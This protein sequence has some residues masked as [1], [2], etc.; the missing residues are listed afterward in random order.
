MLELPDGDFLELAWTRPQAGPIVI[1][2]H[3]LEGSYQSPYA[4]GIA[5]A[6]ERT[7]YNVVIAHFRGCGNRLNRLPRNYHAG[8][9]GDIHHVVAALHARYPDRQLACI[10]Y[11]LGGNQLLKWLGEQREAAPIASA[12]A[13]SVPFDLTVSADTLD[14]GL[15]RHY[16]RFLVGQLVGKV[17]RKLTKMSL[18]ANVRTAR[19]DDRMTF[20]EF[21]DAV[22]APLHGFRDVHH[23]YRSSSSRQF[24]AQIAVPT[25]ILQ[26]EDDPFMHA[27]GLPGASELGPA[28]QF[29]LS[30]GGGHVGFV[31]GSLL[32]PEYWLEE[33]IP[34]YLSSRLQTAPGGAVVAPR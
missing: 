1:V 29:E 12:V 4:S 5:G 6:L 31:A 26:A 3:G 25:L 22:T 28:V 18:P 13:V 32:T 15:A 27:R 23:Y 10:G 33:R 20:W 7:G 11:S 30:A 8:D 16:Q 9:T 34:A 21:D 14:Q 17:R 19:L 24:L 2:F